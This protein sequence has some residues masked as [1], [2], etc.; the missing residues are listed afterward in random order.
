MGKRVHKSITELYLRY[1][2][3]RGSFDEV[4]SEA[5]IYCYFLARRFFSRNDDFFTVF[6]LKVYEK[7]P[8]I[9]LRFQYTGTPIEHFLAKSVIMRCRSIVSKES[10]KL[11]RH[12]ITRCYRFMSVESEEMYGYYAADRSVSLSPCRIHRKAAEFLRADRKGRICDRF[13]IKRLLI[14][15][16]READKLDDQLIDRVCIV[17]GVEP[18]W[19]AEMAGRLNELVRNRKKR[20]IEVQERRNKAL[21]SMVQ[22][23]I[24]LSICLEKEEKDLIRQEILRHRTKMEKLESKLSRKPWRVTNTELAKLLN[25]PVGSIGS[26]LYTLLSQAPGFFAEEEHQYLPLKPLDD[27]GR[28]DAV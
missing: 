14:L 2:E 7:I 3:G 28:D 13:A 25:I 1:N 10:K 26:S 17:T 24:A 18:V 23:E 9:I 20:Y 6:I 27:L 21:S 12:R 19:L 5:E 15:A 22:A 11:D 8:D 4:K 16:L